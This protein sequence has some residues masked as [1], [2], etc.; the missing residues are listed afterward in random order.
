MLGPAFPA[1]P[2]D[3]DGWLTSATCTACGACARPASAGGTQAGHGAARPGRLAPRPDG[4]WRS[5]R[6]GPLPDGAPRQRAVPRGQPPRSR[7]RRRAGRLGAGR[8]RARALSASTRRRAG[9]ASWPP[10]SARRSCASP[11]TRAGTSTPR[12]TPGPSCP[13]RATLRWS[14]RAS[15]VRPRGEQPAGTGEPEDERRTRGRKLCGRGLHTARYLAASSARPA[16]LPLCRVD[17]DDAATP[18]GDAATAG[19]PRPGT[20]GSVELWWRV[21]PP[22]SPLGAPRE[23]GEG[24]AKTFSAC[25]VRSRVRSTHSRYVVQT[26]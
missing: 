13:A 11:S 4:F 16:C 10:L 9:G 14:L 22:G 20:G 17:A 5:G 18:G 3:S 8:H 1:W 2:G 25:R 6:E 23:E 7:P 24:C 26:F 12:G 15:K 19:R 21:L